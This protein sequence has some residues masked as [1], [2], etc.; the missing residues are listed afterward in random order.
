MPIE[1]FYEMLVIDTPEKAERLMEA[2]RAA[3]RRGPY[4][5]EYDTRK[6]LEEGERIVLEEYFAK[7]KE[8]KEREETR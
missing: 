5:P 1:S 2:F 8:E 4:V 6:E 3:E 7:L